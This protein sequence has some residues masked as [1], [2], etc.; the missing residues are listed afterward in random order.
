M[1]LSPVGSVE[2]G[3]EV[4]A[5]GLA[6]VTE[7]P[8]KG[9]TVLSVVLDESV[10]FVDQEKLLRSALVQLGEDLVEGRARWQSEA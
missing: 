4:E 8:K 2:G 9:I 1:A 3:D 6:F 10:D 7:P 5:V